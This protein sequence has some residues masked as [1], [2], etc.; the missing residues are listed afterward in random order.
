MKELSITYAEENIHMA[1]TL[2]KIRGDIVTNDRKTYYEQ[3]HLTNLLKWY[4]I[5]RLIYIVILIAFVIN[6]IMKMNGIIIKIAVI[7]FFTFYPI[8]STPLINYL[9]DKIKSLISLLPKN[10]YK[11]I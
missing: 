1:N 7:L 5:I 11:S 9:I 3:Q 6:I 4:N 2:K 8:F 10:V